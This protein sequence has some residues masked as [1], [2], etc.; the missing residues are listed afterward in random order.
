MNALALARAIAM[1]FE[2]CHLSPYHC[3]AGYPTIGWGR[4]LSR[5]RGD[6]LAK[7][8][9][10]SQEKADAYLGKDLRAAR[11]QVR[12]LITAPLTAGQEAALIDFAYNLGGA[13][14]QSS[15]L[16]RVINRGDYGDAPAQFARWVYAAGKPLRG[17]RRRRQREIEAWHGDL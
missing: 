2:G 5:R 8:Q 14:L 15:T 7:W 13:N 9:P 6:R 10:I 17:L 16:R 1:D 11:R 12:R 4:L 3:P